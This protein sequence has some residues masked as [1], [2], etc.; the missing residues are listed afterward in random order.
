LNRAYPPA[1][2]YPA[3][4]MS[5]SSKWIRFHEMGLQTSFI[6]GGR[7]HSAKGFL[8]VERGL[9][10]PHNS[11]KKW[12]PGTELNRR[13]QPF[14]GCALPPELPGHFLPA[15]RSSQPAHKTTDGLPS[16]AALARSTCALTGRDAAKQNSRCAGTVRNSRIIT[17]P[18]RSS[19]S[20][21]EKSRAMLFNARAARSPRHS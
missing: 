15:H 12:W 18:C 6:V 19:K 8:A 9:T 16:R 11:L 3:R 4:R 21:A 17:T 13:R 20:W 7:M 10:I 5:Y 1:N 2:N 14:Q